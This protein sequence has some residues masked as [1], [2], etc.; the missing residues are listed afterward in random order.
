MKRPHVP[1]EVIAEFLSS[2]APLE[3]AYTQSYFSYVAVRQ[4]SGYAIIKG[5]LRMSPLPMFELPKSFTSPRVI[6]GAHRLTD[7]GFSVEELVTALCEGKLLLPEGAVNFEP[8]FGE[9][10]HIGFTPLHDEGLPQNRISVLTIEGGSAEG[11]VPSAE[12]DW[13]IKAADVPYDGIGELLTE[14]GLGAL[15]TNASVV[16]IV[17]ETIGFIDQRSRVNG[18]EAKIL[19]RTAPGLSADAVTV[20]YRIVK[21]KRAVTRGRLNGCEFSWTVEEPVMLGEASI[22][23][24]VGS[25]V[26]TIV[27][28]GGL[29]QHQYYLLDPARL[30]NAMRTAFEA[31]DDGLASIT[32]ILDSAEGRSYEAR[33]LEAAVSW[34]LAIHGFVGV[35]IGGTRKQIPGPDNIA[36]SPAGHFAVI[37]CTTK[38]LGSDKKLPDLVANSAKLRRKLDAAGQNHR[39]IL[40]VLVTSLR[41]TD[42]EAE[43]AAA[44]KLGV[45]VLTRENLDSLL[46][47]SITLPDADALYEE[48]IELVRAA[49]KKHQA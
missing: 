10:Y 40:P 44:E 25:V 13:T 9:R 16:E 27:S 35:H 18:T 31:F 1:R 5:R 30:P 41:A 22:E 26:H 21:D 3:S 12:L 6:A 37:E 38:H 19:L 34:I 36:M 46:A 2:V 23:V 14:L 28:C 17:A 43:M 39:S 20:G 4:K 24:P 8:S 47:R 48:G 33:D 32:T 15:R 45:L 7:L 49:R 42:I 29:A 11:L